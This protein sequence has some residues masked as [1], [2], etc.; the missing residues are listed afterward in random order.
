MNKMFYA[1]RKLSYCIC[2]V[3]YLQNFT[4]I[5]NYDDTQVLPNPYLVDWGIYCL[6]DCFTVFSNAFLLTMMYKIQVF[7]WLIICVLIIS[8]NLITFH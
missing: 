4:S 2:C 7:Y 3:L 5:D 8:N 6:D 1:L